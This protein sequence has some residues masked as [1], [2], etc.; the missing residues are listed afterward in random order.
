M[1]LFYNKG[2]RVAVGYLGNLEAKEKKV[3]L[4]ND[5]AE[6]KL[7]CHTKQLIFHFYMKKKSALSLWRSNNCNAF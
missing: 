1:R 7:K 3:R 4:P 5:K 6:F 2:V